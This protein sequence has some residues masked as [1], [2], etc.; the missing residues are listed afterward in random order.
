MFRAAFYKSTR[1][2][3][4]GL[5]NRLVRWWCSGPY[6][7]VEL[8]FS[9]GTAASASFADGGVRFKRINFSLERWDFV[10]LPS[11][12]EPAARAWFAA[13]DG[14][15]YDVLGNIGFA[16]RPIRGDHGAFFCSEAVLAALGVREPWRYDPCCAYSAIQIFNQPASAGFFMSK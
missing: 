13:N 16:W 15:R 14:K 10:D 2:G 5:Y 4:A 12:M 11:C 7:H 8:I 3:L 1:P 9:D 6:S